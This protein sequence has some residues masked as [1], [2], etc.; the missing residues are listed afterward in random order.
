MPRGGPAASFFTR[1]FWFVRTRPILAR[2]FLQKT[3][4]ALPSE[5][6]R[7]RVADR[8]KPSTAAEIAP[9]VWTNAR[10]VREYLHERVSGDPACDWVTWMLHRHVSGKRISALVLG[11]GEGWLERALASHPRIHAVTGVDLSE[12]AVAKAAERAARDG[13]GDRV[14]HAVVDL[15]RDP[16]PGGPYD[17]IFA[18]DVLHHVRGL[19]GLFERIGEAL[20]PEGRL[21]FCEYVGP[22]RF[23]FGRRREAILDAALLSL[24][25]KYRR[26]P[27]GRGLATR[28]HRTDPGEL[29]LRDPSEAIRSDR[30]LSC[31]R[32]SMDVLEE[33]PYGGSLLAPL[34]YELVENF[35]DGDPTDEAVLR[36]LCEQERSMIASGELPSD[37]TVVAA[38]RR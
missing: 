26:L 10:I 11:C 37:Y 16:I 33:I 25:E 8:W 18:H 9:R 29:A 35:R 32:G 15:E 27:D 23:D 24:P 14:R 12:Q 17:V 3:L 4:A 22:A 7:G 6:F 1:A 19:E 13:L 31:V 38:R 20:T 36:G 2:R 28:G 34:L 5:R 21:L 30:I